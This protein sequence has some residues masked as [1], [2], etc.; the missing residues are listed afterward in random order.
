MA[1]VKNEHIIIRVF[2]KLISKTPFFGVSLI[3][4]LIKSRKFKNKKV[5]AIDLVNPNYSWFYDPIVDYFVANDYEIISFGNKY[6]NFEHFSEFIQP[7]INIPLVIISVDAHRFIKKRNH[8][9]IQMFH[10]MVSFGSIWGDEF[11]TRNNAILLTSPFM[12]QQ[13]TEPHYSALIKHHN[14][15]VYHTGYHKID[16]LCKTSSPDNTKQAILYGP[17]WH[18]DFSSIFKWL[19]PIIR[20]AKKKELGLFIKLH[21]YLYKMNDELY[22]GGINW[23]KRINELSNS[24]NLPVTI[25]PNILSSKDMNLIFDSAR[26]M[27][28]DV[29][30]L[31]SEFVLSKQKPILYLD[32]KIKIPENTDPEKF[33]EFAENRI[34]GQIGPIIEKPKELSDS[35]DQLLN[36]N[37]YKSRINHFCKTFVYNLGNAKKQVIYAI[38]EEFDS[39]PS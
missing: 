25:V 10:A 18:R 19:E 38:K 28:T 1:R 39:L 33:F 11:I 15:K 12:A 6:R 22:S 4:Y 21:P 34:R 37:V 26:L 30:S 16:D 27:I 5:L 14:V 31:G 24:Y 7:L 3:S 23:V 2:K 35:I 29:S 17:T 13:L 36:D 32:N 9:I 20:E 8:R